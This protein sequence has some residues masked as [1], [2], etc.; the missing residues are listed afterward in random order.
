VDHSRSPEARV[1]FPALANPEIS[2]RVGA[3]IGVG[4]SVMAV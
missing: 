4:A 1:S 3:A 2:T